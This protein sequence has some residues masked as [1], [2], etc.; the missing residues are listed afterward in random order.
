MPDHIHLLI[1]EPE[2]GTRAGGPSFAFFAKGGHSQLR[3]ACDFDFDFPTTRHVGIGT[4]LVFSTAFHK[5]K[6]ESCDEQPLL[7]T[8]E[9]S[10]IDGARN[11]QES[12]T[13]FRLRYSRPKIHA[14]RSLFRNILRATR[15]ES[16]FCK[17]SGIPLHHNSSGIS[18]LR[19]RDKKMSTRF[20][21]LRAK[22]KGSRLVP[23][24]V[25][26]SAGFR[27]DRAARRGWPG[28]SRR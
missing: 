8:A 15:C 22:S 21:E 16:I 25:I 1:S 13:D 3:R 24:S 17:R 18:I 4:F 10:R 9:R 23:L 28:R 7:S 6:S 11:S 27:P 19:A 20:P 26:R 5:N 12:P 14:S 2:R